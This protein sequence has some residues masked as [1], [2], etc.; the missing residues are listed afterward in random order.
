MTEDNIRITRHYKQKNDTLASTFLNI[1][2]MNVYKKCTIFK[3]V[4]TLILSFLLQKLLPSLLRHLLKLVIILTTS[5]WWLQKTMSLWQE[6]DFWTIKVISLM[7]ITEFFK[8]FFPVFIMFI[9]KNTPPLTKRVCIQATDLLTI[10]I[11]SNWIIIVILLC[12]S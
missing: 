1:I 6:K 12:I 2:L 8:S 5:L 7:S 4:N 3:V 11:M 10:E 9:F